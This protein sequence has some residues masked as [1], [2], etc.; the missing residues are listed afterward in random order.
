MAKIIIHGPA[1]TADSGSALRLTVCGCEVL[2]LFAPKKNT[3]VYHSIRR[4]LLDTCLETYSNSNSAKIGQ[5]EQNM[6]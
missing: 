5:N 1:Q 4:T 3:E 6:R 2:A